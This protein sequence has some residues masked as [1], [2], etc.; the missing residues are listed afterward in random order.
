MTDYSPDRPWDQP[1]DDPRLRTEYVPNLVDLW[2]GQVKTYDPDLPV[3]GLPTELP[4]PGVSASA[5]LSGQRNGAGR[6]DLPALTRLL[7]YSAGVVRYV[8]LEDARGRRYLRAAGSAGATHPLELYVVANGI[9]GLPDGVWHHDPIEHRLVRVGAAPSAGPSYVVITGI[10]WRTGW[11]YYAERGYRHLWWD[12]GSLLAQLLA[13]AESAGIPA[14]LRMTFPDHEVGALV[15]ADGRDEFPLAVV[16]LGTGEPVAKAEG[17]AAAGLVGTNVL[18]FGLV[19]STQRASDVDSWGAGPVP[20]G[21]PVEDPGDT[22]VL[23]ALILRRGSTRTFA[24]AAVLP[25]D[26]LRWA[27][28]AATRPLPWDAGPS[29]LR[30]RIFAHAVQ[31]VRP[32]LYLWSDGELIAERLGDL[33]DEAT[34]FLRAAD[35]RRRQRLHRGAFG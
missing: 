35:A 9:D 11:R 5:A 23:E 24:P 22:D 34:Y 13:L 16:A 8:D 33:R 17:T 2:P 7:F 32:G 12:C 3:V 28:A 15:G 1:Q 26:C 19:T 14:G 21:P 6:L 30:H 10:P 27:F 18:E 4:S 20:A 29:I 25:A 31:G